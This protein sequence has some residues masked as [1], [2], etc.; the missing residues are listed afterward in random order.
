MF[1]ADFQLFSNATSP[2]QTA[3][4]PSSWPKKS[5]PELLKVT[6]DSIVLRLS[7]TWRRFLSFKH[8]QVIKEDALPHSDEKRIQVAIRPE[9]IQQLLANHHLCV[10]DLYPLDP[11]SK[12]CVRIICLHNCIFTDQRSCS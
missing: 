2:V 6:V 9:K 3:N 1:K 10:A 8:M 11:D 7:L 12:Q 5:G 4:K